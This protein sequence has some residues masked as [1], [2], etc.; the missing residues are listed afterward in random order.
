MVCKN[1]SMKQ[2]TVISER[3]ETEGET[4]NYC[5]LLLSENFQAMMQEG[6][7]R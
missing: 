2:R 6:K 1:L 3:W 5:S 4:K 7:P